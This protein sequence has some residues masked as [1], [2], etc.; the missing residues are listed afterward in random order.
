METG[1][2]RYAHGSVLPSTAELKRAE[3]ALEL[4]ADEIVPFKEI[5]TK[6]GK[7][8]KFCEARTLRLACDTYGITEKAKHSP[9]SISESI[10][11]SQVTKNLHVITAGFKMGNVDAVN[12]MTGKPLCVDGIYENIQS[13]DHVFPV[14]LLMAKETKDSY[15]AFKGFFDFFALA[16]DKSKSRDNTPF[17]GMQLRALKRL[18]SWL[19]WTCPP[20]GRDSKGAESA[21]SDV[22]FVIAVP[23]SQTRSIIPMR[24]NA[25]DF[26]LRGMMKVGCVTTTPS[27]VNKCFKI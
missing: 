10:D 5:Q 13:R 20:V 19:R 3:K 6:W 22:S 4:K 26:A 23:W 18:S 7:G 24:S 27:Q 14:Q 16:G 2:K 21:S 12:L 11:V 25:I 17:F 8:I 1:G 9:I 15:E